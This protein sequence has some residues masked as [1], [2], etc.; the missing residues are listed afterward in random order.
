M[1]LRFEAWDQE[2]LPADPPKISAEFV[3]L[4]IRNPD[5]RLATV[6]S[7]FFGNPRTGGCGPFAS[8]PDGKVELQ[9]FK[10]PAHYAPP[11]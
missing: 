5:G 8:L 7:D 11:E 6:E 4:P 3:E 10:F 9:V 1:K 2:D